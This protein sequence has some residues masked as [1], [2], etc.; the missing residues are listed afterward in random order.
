[1]GIDDSDYATSAATRQ[2]GY[3]LKDFTNED[4]TLRTPF[5]PT[6][7]FSTETP[8]LLTASPT[9]SPTS[10]CTDVGNDNIPLTDGMCPSWVAN[11]C[12]KSSADPDLLSPDAAQPLWAWCTR[13]LPNERNSA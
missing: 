8:L 9:A 7:C 1:M 3:T 12:T 5:T 6:F 11:H 2:E 4:F 10:S 13:R